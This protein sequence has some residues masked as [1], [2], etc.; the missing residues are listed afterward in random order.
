MVIQKMKMEKINGNKYKYKGEMVIMHCSRN[1]TCQTLP[2][3][4]ICLCCPPSL[5]DAITPLVSS[6]LSPYIY[7]S[8][9]Q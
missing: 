3:G 2:L 1:I 9:N 5:A 6:L 7:H 8:N 4:I